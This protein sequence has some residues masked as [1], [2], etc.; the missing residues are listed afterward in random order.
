MRRP[1]FRDGSFDAM[2]VM[3]Y[4]R[5]RSSNGDGTLRRTRRDTWQTLFHF[6]RCAVTGS[7]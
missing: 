7:D 6:K 1:D 4:P 5:R 3:H 2:V